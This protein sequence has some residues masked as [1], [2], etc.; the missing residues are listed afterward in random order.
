MQKGFVTLLWLAERIKATSTTSDTAFTRWLKKQTRLKLSWTLF[1]S[2]SKFIRNK[3]LWGIKEMRISKRW[4][5]FWI[6]SEQNWG[7]GL[8]WKNIRENLSSTKYWILGFV[9]SNTLTTWFTWDCL[10]PTYSGASSVFIIA[11]KESYWKKK[12]KK[13]RKYLPCIEGFRWTKKN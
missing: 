6:S 11:T 9:F 5:N 10:F 1:G 7:S 2:F 4:L 8:A 3:N 13:V 12:T